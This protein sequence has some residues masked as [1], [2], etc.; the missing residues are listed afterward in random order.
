MTDDTESL[1]HKIETYGMTK[2]SEDRARHRIEFEH[3]SR[4]LASEKH[5][6]TWKS[7]FGLRLF[8]GGFEGQGARG[9]KLRHGPY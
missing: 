1:I 2:V 5:F 3:T 8:C 4:L 6:H 7:P 9:G